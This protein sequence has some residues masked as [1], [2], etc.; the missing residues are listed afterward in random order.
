MD[1]FF[2]LRVNH[3]AVGNG[4]I[5]LDNR[6][7]FLD[8]QNRY[9]PLDFRADD[10]AAAMGY[11]PASAV[12]EEAYRIDVSARDLTLAR[13]GNLHGHVPPVH[14]LLKASLDLG[15]D[16]VKLRELK[17]TAA[18][19]DATDRSLSIAGSLEH[20]SHPHWQATVTGDLDLRLLDPVLGFNLAPEGLARLNLI[21]GGLGGQFHID[22]KVNVEDASYLAPGVVARNVDLTTS[23]HADQ[24]ALRITSVDARLAGG[25]DVTGEV[26][27]QHWI[28][29]TPRL[30][31]EPISESVRPLAPLRKKTGPRARPQAQPRPP[32]PPHSALLKQIIPLIPVTGRVNAELHNVSLDELLDIVGQPPFQRLGIDALLN[33]PAHATWAHGDDRT[34]SVSTLLSLVPS[35]HA[36]PGESPANGAVDATY[37]HKDG[38]VDVRTL[39]LNLPASRLSAQGQLG[40]FPLTSPTNLTLNFHS[41]NLGEF[42]TVLRDLGFVRDGRSGVAALPVALTGQAGFRGTWTGSLLSPRFTGTLSATQATMEIPGLAEKQGQ[43]QLVHWDSIAAQGSYS[44]DRIVI[45]NGELD[46]GSSQLVVSG[47]LAASVSGAGTQPS[48]DEDS[49]LHLHAHAAKLN[50]A[51]MMPLAG[52]DLPV[53]GVL[54]AQISADGPLHAPEGSGWAQLNDAVV[55]GQPVSNLRAQGT[56]QGRAVRLSSIALQTPAGSAS[57]TG[58]YDL[59]TRQFQ[60]EADSSGIDVA[61]IERLHASGADIDGK[62]SLHLIASGTRDQPKIDGHASVAGFSMGGEAMGT[63]QMTA[64]T[65]NRAL[66]Y[67]VGS[68]LD[69]AELS[70]HGQTELSGDYATQANIE[71]AQFDVATIFRLAHVEGVGAQSSLS[72]TGAVSGPLARPIEMRG[73]L[74]IQQ[75]AMTVAGVH[76]KSEGGVHAALDNAR[77]DSRPRAHYRRGHRPAPLRHAQPARYAAPRRGGQRQREPEAGAD[78]GQRFDRR[79]YHYFSG[80]SPRSAA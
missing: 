45:Q 59:D 6:A 10:F 69:A 4:V 13:S 64:H 74:R 5:D 76:L 32:A 29:P 56:L 11:L 26:L 30:V 18:V 24:D 19:P 67:D 3:V 12:A 33:G 23:V 40:A 51:D 63:L 17:L 14:G 78:T 73:D 46:R 48:F 68:R 47:S 37:T 44:A 34:L 54:D 55:Y 52:L 58:S 35:G 62:L 42:D 77:A 2:R 75:V 43:P 31:M 80:G 22:G 57:G 7:A 66:V 38:A 72:G 1:K 39:S 71:V 21:C 25:G 9:Q 70:L 20:F 60:A 16:D 61:K 49:V 65:V 53:T 41:A 15:R 27:L 8:F 28:Q 79:R 50:V 36:P